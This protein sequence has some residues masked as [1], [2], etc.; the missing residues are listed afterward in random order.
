MQPK[1]TSMQ[2]SDLKV[3]KV[4]AGNHRSKLQRYQELVIGRIGLGALIRYELAALLSSGVPGALGL[5][6]RSK[7]YPPLLGRVGRNVIFGQNVVLR[8]PHKI[9]IGDDVIIDDNCLLDAKGVKNTG[10]IIGNGVFLGRN[11]I[12]SCKDG[13][14]F[15][16]DGVNLGFNCEVFSESRVRLGQNALVAA[17]CYFIGGGSYDLS[18]MDVSF[19]EQDGFSGGGIEV[20]ASTWFGAGVKIID[21]V[22]IGNGAVVGAGAVVT[23]NL[24]E[25]SVAAGVPARV[26]KER[27]S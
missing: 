8:H 3:R 19:S 26:L 23:K 10:I 7:L 1:Q 2:K 9:F 5:F 12:L 24:P 6:L 13:D 25:R 17:Y 20:G 11:T 27:A 16:E 21:G 4:L 22:T 15:L 14:I 18:R